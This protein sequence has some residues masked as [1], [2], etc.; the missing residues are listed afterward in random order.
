MNE[1]KFVDIHCHILPGIDDGASD[2]KASLAMAQMASG[3]GISTIIA[4]PHQLGSFGQNRGNQIRELVTADPGVAGCGPNPACACCPA[5]MCASN[6]AWWTAIQT[7]EVL[8]LADLRQTCAVG[9][10]P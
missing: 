8:T 7:G 3:D 10:A 1:W 4:T 2:L 9:I 6:Q 5:P